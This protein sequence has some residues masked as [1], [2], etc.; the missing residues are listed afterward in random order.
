MAKHGF[1][2][3]PEVRDAVRR[4]VA[5]AVASIDPR[6]YRQEHAYST[7]LAHAL[8]GVPYSGPHG[9]V[10]FKSTVVDDRGRGAAEKWSGADLAITANVSYGG[11]QVRKAILVQAKRGQLLI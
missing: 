9:R 2:F 3:Q 6:R 11:Q 8:E 5:A 1:R 7:A 10:E 4:H